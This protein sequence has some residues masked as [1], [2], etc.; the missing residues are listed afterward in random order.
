MNFESC[1]R[2]ESVKCLNVNKRL[3]NIRITAKQTVYFYHL[4]INYRKTDRKKMKL[5]QKHYIEARV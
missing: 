2:S 4:L 1:C 3:K 5:W